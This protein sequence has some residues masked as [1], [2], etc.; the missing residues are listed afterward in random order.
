MINNSKTLKI[1]LVCTLIIILIFVGVL[2]YKKIYQAKVPGLVNTQQSKTDSQYPVP[3][4]GGAFAVLYPF[5]PTSDFVSDAQAIITIKGYV[6]DFSA[7]TGTTAKDYMILK[8]RD[9]EGQAIVNDFYVK[10]DTPIIVQSENKQ[11]KGSS[12]D[13]TSNSLVNVVISKNVKKNA[14]WNVSKVIVLQ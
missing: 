5:N 6:T 14:Q 1:V 11:S 4:S 7:A 9:T 13:I 2:W 10:N 3:N 8:L 12:Q